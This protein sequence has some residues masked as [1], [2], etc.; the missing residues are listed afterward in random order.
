M[1]KFP[2]LLITLILAA[3][4]PSERTTIE[5]FDDCVAAG[6][7]IMESYPQQCR[8]KD[9]RL[10]R[11]DIGDEMEK[12]DLIRVDLPRPNQ[13]ISSPVTI[14]GEARGYW[15]FEATF[16]IVLE[17]DQGDILATHYAT[18]Q[19]EWMTEDFVPF[20]SEFDVIFGDATKGNLILKKN[21]PSDLPENDDELRI[22]VTFD[23]SSAET[24]LITLSFYSEDDL[25]NAMFDS[26]VTVTRTIPKTAKVAEATLLALFNGPTEEEELEGAR[27]SE[28][29]EKLGEYYLG[30]NIHAEYQDPLNPPTNGKIIENVAIVNFRSEALSILNSAAARQFMVKSAIEETLRHFPTITHILYAIDGEVFDEWDA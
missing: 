10:F 21:N 27:S 2:L 18:A 3:C 1:K 16:P 6:N 7:P 30:I 28:D 25:S 4:T 20:T 17:D 23:K 11:E 15:F 19:G 5:N 9:G 13:A 24:S 8:T 22:P 14:E 26:P 29:L 12:K